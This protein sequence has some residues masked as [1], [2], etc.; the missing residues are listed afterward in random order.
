MQDYCSRY[1][2]IPS[3]TA[4]P[5]AFSRHIL[6]DDIHQILFCFLPKV[7]CTNL[8]LLFFASQGLI[9]YSE[10]QKTR[11]SIDQDRLM[12]VVH[13]QSLEGNKLGLYPDL[14]SLDYFKYVMVRNPLERLA[15]AYR[16]KIERFNLT[17]RLKDTPHYN[18]ARRAIFKRVYPV[19][20]RK[21]VKEGMKRQVAISFSDFITY[22]LQPNL[23][24]FKYDD[25]FMSFLHICQPCRTRFDFYGN[26]RH[27]DRDAQ[28]LIDKIG[29]SS[30][31]LRQ[32]YYSDDTSSTDQRMR[33][34]YSTLSQSQKTDVLRKM[35][36]E[37]E[38]HY[39]IFP[40]ER[41]SHK[42][43]LGFDYDLELPQF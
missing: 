42:Q 33:L 20:Y 9:P 26:F 38:F 5:L 18:W 37:L 13:R 22:W 15:S 4:H 29:A 16:S 30:S 36:L 3:L 40:E 14:Q 7:G 23:I 11:D 39:T 28:V 6:L 10:L 21:W 1:D 19:E 35:A 25:H 2:P 34:Y 8:K 41:D 27:F 17:G 43:I 24:E 31:D 32:G 12:K